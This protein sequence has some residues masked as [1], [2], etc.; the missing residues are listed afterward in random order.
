MDKNCVVFQENM[1]IKR[2]MTEK[3]ISAFEASRT[4][5]GRCQDENIEKE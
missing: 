4:V 5:I 1:E 3:N 2:L